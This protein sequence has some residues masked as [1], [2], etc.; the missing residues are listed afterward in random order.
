MSDQKPNS[1]NS[2][3]KPRQ[4]EPAANTVESPPGQR[5]SLLNKVAPQAPPP[6]D[7]SPAKESLLTPIE[8]DM[9]APQPDPPAAEEFPKV[10]PFV[11]DPLELEDEVAEAINQ[12]LPSPSLSEKVRRVEDAIRNLRVKMAAIAIE[13]AEGRIN[14]AQFEAIYNRFQEQRAI[15][16]SLLA[17]DPDSEAWQHVLS[18]GST[19]FLRE[20]YEAE[21]MNCQCEQKPG[22]ARP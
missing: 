16:E 14:Q 21:M 6:S 2:S 19:H 1:P 9:P 4:T 5:R 12:P 8:Q 10:S 7:T 15:T 13:L 11:S 3:P 18:E 20:L 17:R 22:C